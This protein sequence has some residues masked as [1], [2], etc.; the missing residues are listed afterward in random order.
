MRAARRTRLAELTAAAVA[1]GQKARPVLPLV[2]VTGFAVYGQVRYGY[3][4][5]PPKGTLELGKWVIALGAAVAVESIALYVAWHAH[6]ALLAG[7]TA[8]AARL[9]RA[10]YAIA[11]GVAGINYAHFAADWM[12][13]PA[14]VVF[15]LFSASSPWL[16]GLHT[17]RAQHVQLCARARS[18]PPEPCSPPNAAAP[19]PCG[20]SGPGAGR[21]T[22]ASPTPA[23]HGPG[24]TATGPLAPPARLGRHG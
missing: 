14:A 5:Y 18:T 4:H 3:A 10:S 13:T 7:A 11:L 15:G 20:P 16:W 9:R 19:F 24:T 2:V 23:K 6:D 12:P 17:R 21:S 22:T 8:T 1:L